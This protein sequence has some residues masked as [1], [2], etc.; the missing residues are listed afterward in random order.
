MNF[1]YVDES[2]RE[3]ITY[4]M[5]TI[6]AYDEKKNLVEFETRFKALRQS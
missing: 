3:N 1:P 5:V 2:F 4:N 6:A